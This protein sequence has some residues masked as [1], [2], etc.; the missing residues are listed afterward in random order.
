MESSHKGNCFWDYSGPILVIACLYIAHLIIS[1]EEH[2]ERMK[3]SKHPRFNLWTFPVLVEGPFEVVSAAELIGIVLFVVFIVMAVYVYTIRNFKLLEEF[4][5]PTKEQSVSMLELT[6]LRFGMIGLLCMV[7]LFLPVARGSVLL[8]LIDIPFEHA[9]RYHVWLG[10]LTLY[11]S[12]PILCNWMG[13]FKGV[14]FT[15]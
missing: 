1:G 10:H 15:K 14:S 7:F 12:W 9:T 11:S 5:V 13:Q 3:T 6:G 8:R 2:L 4:Q